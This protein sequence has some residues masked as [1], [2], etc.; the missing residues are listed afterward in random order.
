MVYEWET[1]EGREWNDGA[2]TEMETRWRKRS[3]YDTQ[4]QSFYFHLS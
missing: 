1:E 2:E 4:N 3:F